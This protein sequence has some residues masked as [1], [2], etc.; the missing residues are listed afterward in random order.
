MVAV[1]TNE[2]IAE[3]RAMIRRTTDNLITFVS[4]P[5]RSGAQLRNVVGDLNAHITTYLSDAT[6]GDR[7]LSCFRLATDAGISLAWLDKVLRG[8]VE[9]D[10]KSVSAITV[11]QNAFIMALAQQARIIAKTTF[12]SRDE[13]D[14]TMRRQKVWF[15][16]ARDYAAE[17]M[18][19]PSYISLLEMAAAMTRYL[20]DMARPLPRMVRYELPIIWPS[21]TI[22]NYI[23]G[24]ATHAEDI[25]GENRIVHPLFV[26][27]RL[28]ALSA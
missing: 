19:N 4:K 24:E 10:P 12:R 11:M 25:A 5:G 6:F 1:T 13:V 14:A 21:L 17:R 7:L 15:D 18:A 8:L 22:S 3:I 28:K 9:E 26:K 23:Y 2:D 16:Q 27:R 20:T